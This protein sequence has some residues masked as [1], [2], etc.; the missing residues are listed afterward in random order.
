MNKVIKIILISV[1]LFLVSCASVST[2]TSETIDIKVVNKDLRKA[3]KALHTEDIET[4]LSITKKYAE[5][6]NA[7]AQFMYGHYI[8]LKFY[9]ENY[10]KDMT[11]RVQRQE[12]LAKEETLKWMTKSA[13][14]GYVGGQAYL[15]GYFL[16]GDY[17]RNIKPERVK[18]L[19][20]T[21]LAAAQL[22]EKDSVESAIEEARYNF[23]IT[24]E[25]IK[26]AKELAKTW[27]VDSADL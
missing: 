17:K 25:D 6:G 10:G 14:Q 20:W 4:A 21:I 19:M 12:N 7:K 16:E 18:G 2:G 1:S 3:E 15:G 13:K 23:N 11:R 5:M 22:K 24:D 8:Y 26:K 27:K 9:V